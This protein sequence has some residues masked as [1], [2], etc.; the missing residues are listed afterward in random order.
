MAYGDIQTTVNVLLA[1]AAAV[2]VVA[3]CVAAFVKLYGWATKPTRENTQHNAE[4]D[5]RLDEGDER[6][7]AI[8]QQ[9]A[10]QIEVNKLQMRAMLQM[11]NHMIDGNHVEQLK[12]AR[13]D[14]ELFL[15]NK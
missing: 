14:I 11:M 15:I 2:G 4:T 6:M 10:S 7:T 3:G 5:R 13:D 1:F 12:S 8:E 9:L